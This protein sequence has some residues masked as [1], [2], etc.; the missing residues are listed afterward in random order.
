MSEFKIGDN[1]FHK[2][3]ST[4][5]WTIEKIENNEAV[6]STLVKDTYEQKKAVF[7]LTSISKC[8]EPTFIVGK[9][10]RN[11]HY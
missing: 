10:T 2:S 4:V 9:R 7:A 11:N 5:A 3:N 1:I 8:A 6:C